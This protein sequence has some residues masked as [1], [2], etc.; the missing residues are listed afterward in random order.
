MDMR[1]VV[2]KVQLW[3]S[4]YRVLVQ[5]LMPVSECCVDQL[6]IGIGV[7][8]RFDGAVQPVLLPGFQLHLRATWEG[9]AWLWAG[10]GCQDASHRL[11]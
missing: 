10:G 1:E 4:D 7:M 9:L 2:R 6:M 11:C 3:K 8:N 5:T